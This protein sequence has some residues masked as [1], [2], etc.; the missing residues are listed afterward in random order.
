M[1]PLVND[2]LFFIIIHEPTHTLRKNKVYTFGHGKEYFQ[3]ETSYN[4]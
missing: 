4:G 1:N 2:F 3:N